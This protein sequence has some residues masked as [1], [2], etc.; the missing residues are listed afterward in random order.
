[1]TIS[2]TAEEIQ[3]LVGSELGVQLSLRFQG[4]AFIT[5]KAKGV[6]AELEL[7]AVV[8]PDGSLELDM[9]QVKAAGL[10]LFGVPRKIV[11]DLI[12][13][14]AKNFPQIIVVKN[15]RGNLQLSIPGCKFLSCDFAGGRLNVVCLI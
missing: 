7:R 11:G 10:G 9:E 13:K 1:M 5:V 15:D 2:V 3:R 6:T 4:N 14:Q 8:L 12:V